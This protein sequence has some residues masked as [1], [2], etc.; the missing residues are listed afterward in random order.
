MNRIPKSGARI[1][2]STLP[3]FM[4]S[5]YN[6]I[7]KKDAEGEKSCAALNFFMPSRQ[8][9]RLPTSKF[10]SEFSFLTS[11]ITFHVFSFSCVTFL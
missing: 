11:E 8:E 6:I 4:G 5:V 9:C 2:T 1:Y 7:K 10:R 3:L